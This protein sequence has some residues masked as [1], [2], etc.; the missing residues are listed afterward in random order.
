M[1]AVA[2]APTAPLAPA[3]APVRFGRLLLSEWTKLHSVRSTVAPP[4]SP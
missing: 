1:T 3:S 4:G 2:P